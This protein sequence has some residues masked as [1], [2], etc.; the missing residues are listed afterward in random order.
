M[1]KS[2]QLEIVR[3][4]PKVTLKWVGAELSDHDFGVPEGGTRKNRPA[5]SLNETFGVEVGISS[6]LELSRNWRTIINIDVER[7]DKE[8]IDSPIVN[9]KWIIKGFTAVNFVF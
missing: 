8:I 1:E 7:L 4:S 9:E 6:F 5:Y 3:L 2:F